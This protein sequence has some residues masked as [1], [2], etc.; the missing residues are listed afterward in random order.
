MTKAHVDA[1]RRYDAKKYDRYTLR[2]EKE[3]MA[4]ARERA[5]M[6]DPGMSLNAYIVG[7]IL[8]DIDR[9]AK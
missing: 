8:D 3:D 7:L 1:V 4:K 9:N 2:L 5:A 6:I